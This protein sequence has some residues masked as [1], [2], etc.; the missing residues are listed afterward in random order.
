MKFVEMLSS[1]LSGPHTEWAE[2]SELRRQNL[3][4]ISYMSAI[5]S[6][7][8]PEAANKNDDA[9]GF[10]ETRETVGLSWKNLSDTEFNQLMSGRSLP[11]A[12]QTTGTPKRF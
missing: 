4:T 7:S 10:N 1:F 3:M 12:H 9:F 8:R 2:L 5:S 11:P 6:Q